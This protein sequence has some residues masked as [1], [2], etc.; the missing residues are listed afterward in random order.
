M[1][2]RF[3]EISEESRIWNGLGGKLE[4][5][6]SP[7]LAA[8]REIFEESEIEV[9]LDQILSLGVLYF[10]HFKASRNED[11]M[12]FVYF[13]ELSLRPLIP[14]SIR[15]GELKW[16]EQSSI[17]GLNLWP[18]DH[19]FLPYVLSKTAFQGTL[20][21]EDGKVIRHQVATIHK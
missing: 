12:V 21:Y 9:P 8:Q 15:E 18:G 7:P 2:H 14:K 10:P 20:W 6:E 16:V 5:G 4:V 13:V 1:I 17:S 3:S 19:H 11:W